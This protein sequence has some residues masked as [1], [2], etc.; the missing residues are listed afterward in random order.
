MSPW[1]IA[2][3]WW[4]LLIASTVARKF[5]KRRFKRGLV[6]LEILVALYLA[7][8]VFFPMHKMPEPTGKNEVKTDRIYFEHVTEYPEMATDG[9]KREIPVRVYYPENLKEKSHPLFLFSHGAFG[10]GSSNETL[11]FELASHGYIVMALEHP[12][13]AFF[14]KLSSGKTIFIDRTFF[15]E[16]V[17]SKGAEDL[18]KTR[19]DLNRWVDPRIEDIGFVLDKSLDDV[20][21][22]VYEDKI[23]PEKIVLSGHSL[24][25]SAALAIG[26]ERPERIR[27][28]V[29]LE[30]PFVKEIVAI[31]GEEY[32]FEEEEYPRPILHIY[33]DALWHRMDEIA[34]YGLNEEMIEGRD[35]KFPYEHIEGVGHIGLTDLSLVSPFLTN[36]IDGGMDEKEAEE[37]LL[38]INAAVRCFLA[39]INLL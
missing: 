30:A 16:V 10:I 39:E 6:F 37:A 5:S 36:A 31:E 15:K 24:G 33:S 28:L 20:K 12:H 2:L 32:L 17:A 14:A 1:T 4:I 25:G 29:I 34:T 38:E 22:N 21:D 26:R 11:Y 8:R 9:E 13:H 23:D 18:E 7:F 19:G 27:A 3:A 35:P